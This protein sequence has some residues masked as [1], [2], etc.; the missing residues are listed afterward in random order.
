MDT[1]MDTIAASAVFA[2]RPSL[3]SLCLKDGTNR[4]RWKSAPIVP[5]SAGP[6][7][8]ARIHAVGTNTPVTKPLSLKALRERGLFVPS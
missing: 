5:F 2:R 7:S 1:T 8:A 3:P 4:A 6:I